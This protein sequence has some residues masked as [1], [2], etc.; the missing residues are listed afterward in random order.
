M[1]ASNDIFP[2]SLS[3]TIRLEE[4]LFELENSLE[5]KEQEIADLTQIASIITSILDLESILAVTMETSIRRVGGEVGAILLAEGKDLQAKISWGVDTDI[6]DNLVYKDGLPV[7]R[8]CF[9]RRETVL[10]NDSAALPS[11]AYSIH[12]LIASPILVQAAAVGVVIIF[13]KDGDGGF[14]DQDRRTLDMICRFAAIAIENARLVRES[15]EKQKIEQELDL[16]RQIQTTFL[17][18]SYSVSGLRIASTYLPAGQIGGD[19]YDIITLSDHQA[20]FLVGDVSNKGVPAALVMTAVYSIVRAYVGSGR[21]VTVQTIMEHLNNLLCR[22]II[23][24]RDMF[25]TL[26]LAYIDTARGTLDFCNGGHPPSFLYCA[27]SGETRRLKE[28]G[29]LVGQFPGQQ[30]TAGSA[31]IGPGDRIFCYTDGLIEAESQ[32]GERYGI[33]RLEQLFIS[34]TATEADDFNREV[35]EGIAAFST[36]MARETRDDYTTLV[37]DILAGEGDG[38]GYRFRYPSTLESLQTMYRDLDMVFS[39]HG[40]APEAAQ[41]FCLAVSEAVT[42]AIVHAHGEDARKPV[43]VNIAVNDCRI[44]ADIL[45]EGCGYHDDILSAPDPIRD[46]NAESGR[47]MGLIRHLSDEVTLRP[48]PR[49]GTAL[50]IVKQYCR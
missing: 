15:V 2:D 4:R 24:G 8:Y 6:L 34:R 21:E 47:G 41:P 19:Y 17:P 46:P 37:I 23:R 44:T 36:G 9:E 12:S 40:I 3:G 7:A 30:Y 18:D 45:D 33:A 50:R 48:S 1:N 10:E 11:A 14:S 43:E 25:I 20:L 39:R 35:R 5:T 49:G 42:N 26:F 13:N 32:S 16:A 31:M 38:A 29:P 22:D 27:S 28:G